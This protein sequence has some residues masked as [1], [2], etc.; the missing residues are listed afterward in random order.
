[1]NLCN[2]AKYVSP[3][4]G[5]GILSDV[6]SCHAPV[7]HVAAEI[8]AK[9]DAAT[10]RASFAAASRSSNRC[11]HAAATCHFFVSCFLEV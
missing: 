10:V 5:F 11:D 9:P 1:M 4:S 8:A 7:A 6:P 3:V 2:A